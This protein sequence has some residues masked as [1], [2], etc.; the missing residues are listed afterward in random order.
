MEE[1]KQNDPQD[2]NEQKYKSI[3]C[4]V[5]K[6]G[7]TATYITLLRHIY[8]DLNDKSLVMN[9]VER[10]KVSINKQGK[11]LGIFIYYQE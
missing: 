3:K 11:Q 5:K 7:K 10:L 4:W 2:Y 1:I 9:I 6:N 8:F